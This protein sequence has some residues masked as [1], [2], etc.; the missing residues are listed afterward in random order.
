METVNELVMDYMHVRDR[1]DR[2]IA[3]FQQNPRMSPPSVSPEQGDRVVRAW[4]ARL[5]T[6]Q[7]EY[8]GILSDI[9][10]VLDVPPTPTAKVTP[11]P[12]WRS[13]WRGARR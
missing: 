5:K 12:G 11:I 7:R 8:D 3:M 1:L 13:G 2:Q 6:C 9:C 4:I 10:S